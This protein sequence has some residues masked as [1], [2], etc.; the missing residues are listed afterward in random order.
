MNIKDFDFDVII[1]GARPSGASLSIHLAR[2]GFSVLLVDKDDLSSSSPVSCPII[3]A[4]TMKLLDDLEVDESDYAYNTPK[5]TSFVVGVKDYFNVAY[6][7]PLYLGRKYAYCIDRKRFDIALLNTVQKQANVS[8][9]TNFKVTGVMRNGDV[10]SGITGRDSRGEVRQFTARCVV[11]AD[12]RFSTVAELVGSPVVEEWK[13]ISSSILY[14]YW[15]DVA[16]HDNGE[17]LVQFYVPRSGLLYMLLD[18]ADN[19]TGV[20]IH[21]RQKY[22]YGK[23]KAADSYYGQLKEAEV[24]WKRLRHAKPVDKLKGIRKLNNTYRKAGGPGW[25]LTGDALHHRD[26]LDAQGIYEALLSSKLLSDAISLLL[27]EGR[28]WNEVVHWYEQT[29]H[30]ITKPM[31]KA[32]L[33]RLV[34]QH[35]IPWPGW[36]I[37]TIIQWIFCDPEYKERFMRLHV[38]D[39][40]PE[41]WIDTRLIIKTLWSGLQ[42]DILRRK[43]ENTQ[44]G[45]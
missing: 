26:T 12:G 25:F 21:G 9:L 19:T 32:T 8:L 22:V 29:V 3:F 5:I 10:V 33:K 13:H 15:Q 40:E 4:N 34:W 41:K 45:I 1:V 17:P 27:K 18:S 2:N 24:I 43:T 37:N 20:I 16:P 39:I 31:C 44:Q 6:K 35:R 42:S 38:R 7:S 14:S 23:R 11:G 30:M 28:P 36:F